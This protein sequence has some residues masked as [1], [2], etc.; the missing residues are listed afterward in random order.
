MKRKKTRKGKIYD[1]FYCTVDSW[2]RDYSFEIK[3]F[4][5]PG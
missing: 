5:I 3:R 2:R 1:D 4:E